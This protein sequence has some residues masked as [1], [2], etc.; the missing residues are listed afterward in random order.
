M[1]SVRRAA[2]GLLLA[3]IFGALASDALAAGTRY[4]PRRAG[5]PLRIIAYALHPVGVILDLLIFHPAW[6]IGKHEPIRTLVGHEARVDE[7]EPLPPASEPPPRPDPESN[8]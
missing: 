8:L 7:A 4:E 6:W 1:R 2:T 5:H 3:T